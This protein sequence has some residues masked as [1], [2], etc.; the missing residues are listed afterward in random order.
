MIASAILL[1]VQAKLNVFAPDVVRIGMMGTFQ[2]Y[3]LPA[4]VTA[5]LST[6]LVKQDAGGRVNPNLV[7]G[8]DVNND[9]TEF[10]F[11]LKDNLYWS[12][13]SKIKSTDLEFSIPNTEVSFPNDKEIL[14]K[15]KQFYSPLPSLLAK[16]VFKK[17]TLTGTGPYRITKI[18]KSRIFITKMILEPLDSKLPTLQLRFYPSEKVAITGF[19]LG[20]VQVLIGLGNIKAIPLNKLTNLRQKTDYS[21]IVTVLFNTSDSILKNRS[22]RQGLAYQTPKIEGEEIANNPYPPLFWARDESAK[23]YLSNE[24]EAKEALQRAKSS[25]SLEQLTGEI[26]LTSTPNLEEVG[27]QIVSQWNKLGFK[28]KLRVESGIPQN[29][30]ALLITQSIP[31]DPDQYFLWHATQTKTNLAKY[32]SKRA[33]KDLEDG[34]KA[35]LEDERKVIYFDFQKTLLEDAPAVFLYFPKYNIVYLKKVESLLNKVLTLK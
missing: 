27:R 33:D 12:D 16:P 31:A 29:F 14:F 32:D 7:A 20:E 8:W 34:R 3:D 11:K 15:L 24:E 19:N 9:A 25:L 30:Q 1:I 4:E 17:G 21:K 35:I 28:A 23:K 6:G 10:K 22:L 18:E 13:S 5:L 2:E 26:I